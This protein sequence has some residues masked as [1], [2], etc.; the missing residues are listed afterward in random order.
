MD[1]GSH[2]ESFPA[3]INTR[4]YCPSKHFFFPEEE[5][6]KKEYTTT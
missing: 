4:A 6:K 3:N 5:E 2:P 1:D